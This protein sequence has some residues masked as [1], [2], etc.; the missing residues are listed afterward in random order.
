MRRLAILHDYFSDLVK[1]YHEDNPYYFYYE[2]KDAIK[3]GN[4]KNALNNINK[5]IG[6]NENISLFYKVKSD[7]L[8]ELGQTSAASRALR[9]AQTVSTDTF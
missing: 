3:E 9:K 4:Y 8:N 2:A 1:K 6:K 5:A 7:I